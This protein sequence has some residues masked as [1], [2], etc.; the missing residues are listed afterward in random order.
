M[1]WQKVSPYIFCRLFFVDL[2]YS[3]ALS[4]LHILFSLRRP[5]YEIGFKH[6]S[7]KNIKPLIEYIIREWNTDFWTAFLSKTH[8]W[9]PRY[10]EFYFGGFHDIIQMLKVLYRCSAYVLCG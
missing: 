7:D 5:V 1:D 9:E 10:R 3:T 6:I 4:Q 8:Q 2:N